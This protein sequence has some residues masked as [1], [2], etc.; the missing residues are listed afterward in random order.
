MSGELEI[1]P[2]TYWINGI[3]LLVYALLVLLIVSALPREIALC[4]APV[5]IVGLISF[6]FTA[7]VQPERIARIRG[8]RLVRDI[9]NI[10]Q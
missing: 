10:L 2:R 5:M 1:L 3:V 7:I 9:Q 6:A 8:G 4:V